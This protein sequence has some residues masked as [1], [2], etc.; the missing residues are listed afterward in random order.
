MAELPTSTRN[1]ITKGEANL[2]YHIVPLLFIFTVAVAF[3]VAWFVSYLTY[4]IVAALWGMT[5][6]FWLMYLLVSLLMTH[7]WAFPFI[8]LFITAITIMV[9]IFEIE[10]G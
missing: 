9:T 7:A 5:F 8:E 6:T 10:V 2:E 4:S 3:L 1:S